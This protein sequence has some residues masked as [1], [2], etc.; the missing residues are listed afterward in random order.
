MPLDRK[1]PSSPCAKYWEE[2][3]QKAILIAHLLEEVIDL[4]IRPYSF[5]TRYSIRGGPDSMGTPGHP[6]STKPTPRQKSTS[7]QQHRHTASRSGKVSDKGDR[8][9]RKGPVD[10]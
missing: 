4:C 6:E 10:L 1:G 8:E 7:A 5:P 3:T 2:C 9:G